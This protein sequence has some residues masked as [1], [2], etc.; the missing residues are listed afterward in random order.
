M[1]PA[2]RH[3][4]IVLL[5][6]A[7]AVVTAPF[8]VLTLQT[9]IAVSTGGPPPSDWQDL[10]SFVI[11]G[12]MI[13]GIYSAVPFLC[14]IGSMRYLRRGDWLTHGI[15]GMATS[16]VALSLFTANLVPLNLA[17]APFL[18][19]GFVAGLIYWLCRRPFGWSWA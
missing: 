13:T 9:A 3:A 2:L 5:G 11:M 1:K 12:V 6:Y 4:L 10:P 14:A 19:A 18:L 7:V 15:A 17:Q 8:L 16:Y